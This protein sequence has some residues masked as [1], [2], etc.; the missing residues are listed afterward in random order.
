MVFITRCKMPKIMKPEIVSFQDK[1]FDYFLWQF[2][3]IR[4]TFHPNGCKL[5]LIRTYSTQE[6]KL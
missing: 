6:T 3:L 2:V 5:G 4:K 1:I